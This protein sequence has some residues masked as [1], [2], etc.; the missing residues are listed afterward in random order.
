MQGPPQTVEEA[1]SQEL[2]L[3][4][5]GVTMSADVTLSRGSYAFVCFMP[6]AGGTPHAMLGMVTESRLSDE[7]SARSFRSSR[8]DRELGRVSRRSSPV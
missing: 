3:I 1:G 6:N 4:S 2:P 8:G 7:V 5:G